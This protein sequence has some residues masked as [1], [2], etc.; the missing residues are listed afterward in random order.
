MRYTKKIDKAFKRAASSYLSEKGRKRNHGLMKLFVISQD[1]NKPS[2]VKINEIPTTSCTAGL[3]PAYDKVQSRTKFV[4]SVINFPKLANST[5]DDTNLTKAK[6]LYNWLF[7]HSPY[8][9]CFVTK[10][11]CKALEQGYVVVDA[12]KEAR[13]VAEALITTRSIWEDYKA[14][15]KNNF[16][17]FFKRGVNPALAWQAAYW[18]RWSEETI[19]PTTLY[20]HTAPQQNMNNLTQ[21]KQFV[22]VGKMKTVPLER[23]QDV[24]GLAVGKSLAKVGGIPTGIISNGWGC[25]DDL[26]DKPYQKFEELLNSFSEDG[27]L[28]TSLLGRS[29]STFLKRVDCYKDTVP[30][31]PEVWD[32]LAEHLKELER[33]LEKI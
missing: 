24:S 20:G 18:I 1:K 17:E 11:A 14:F 8:K 22:V 6:A 27:S 3:R 29:L 12:T 7:N 15:I 32:A 5:G 10:S 33:Q 31:K 19:R 23:Y 4:V 13:L 16:Y 30:N 26:E 9:H 25:D 21:L 2:G 28:V